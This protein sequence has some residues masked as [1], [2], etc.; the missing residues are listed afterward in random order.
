MTFDH[1]NESDSHAVRVVLTLFT[2]LKSNHFTLFIYIKREQAVDEVQSQT[3]S[4]SGPDL[5]LSLSLLVCTHMSG[6]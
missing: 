1:S 3:L 4:S 2:L 6:I 5:P